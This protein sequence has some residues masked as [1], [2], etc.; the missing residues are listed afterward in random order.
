MA[1][2]EF[3]SWDQAIEN[4]P[5]GVFRSDRGGR[6]LY[7]N[8]A[9]ARMFGYK[10]PE[11]LQD[12]VRDIARDLLRRPEQREEVLE[13]LERFGIINDYIYDIVTKDGGQRFVSFSAKKVDRPGGDHYFE[14][15]VH[16]VTEKRL[17]ESRLNDLLAEIQGFAYRCE[18]RHPW[19]MEWVSDGCR[20][21]TGY[22][23][24]ALE[25]RMPAYGDLIWPTHVKDVAD[26]V[27]EAIDRNTTFTLIYPIRTSQ[28]EKKWVFERGRA[29]RD[30]ENKILYLEGVVQNYNDD[31]DWYQHERQEIEMTNERQNQ[32]LRRFMWWTIVVQFIAANFIILGVVVAKCLNRQTNIS[33]TLITALFAGTVG[34]LAAILFIIVKYVFPPKVEGGQR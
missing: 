30:N 22:S 25:N 29:V 6:I 15:F 9:L 32:T 16:D 18:P 27:Q 4:A 20:E 17:A 3:S 2:A 26:S 34:E 5:I 28:G 19:N 24:E 14:G 7:A 12:Q 33:D 23:K 10:S 21:L 8:P 31:R 1:E 11:E 13:E